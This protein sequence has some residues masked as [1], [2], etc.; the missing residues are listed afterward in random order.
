MAR[1]EIRSRQIHLDFHT[2]ELIR[3]IGSRFDPEEFAQTL[4][5]SRVNS[6]TLFSRCHHGMLY[7]DSKRFPERVHPHLANRNFLR[8]Q[9]E[10][11]RKRDIHI[12]LYTTVCWDKWVADRHP[13]WICINDKGELD[14]FK[15]KSYFEAGFYKNL[16]VNTGYRDYLKQQFGEVM[17]TIPAAGVWF[18]AA[19]VTECSCSACI[20]LMQEEGLDP[21][22]KEDRKKFSVISHYRFV[23]EMSDF[24]KK[25]N[26]DYN[27]FY[28]KGHVGTL[29]KGVQEAYTYYSFESLPGGE[30]G[31][32]DFPVSVKYNRNF[33]KEV[34]GLTGRFH[35]EWGDFHSFRNQAALEFECYSMIAQGAKCTIGDQLDPSG[36]LNPYMYEQI[37]AI[38][39]DI[40]RKEPWCE[41]AAAVTEIGVFT[42]EE[43]Y[44]A[45]VGVIPKA[46][47]GVARMLNELAHQ[48]DI[49]D[50]ESAFER[51]KLLILPDVIPVSAALAE[52]LENYVS[53][54]GKLL[55]SH[56]SGLNEEETAFAMDS[57]GLEYLGDAPFSP[58]FI[59]PQGPMGE[60]LPPSEHAMYSKGALVKARHG[61]EVLQEAIVPVFNRTWEH[62][63]SHLHS[64]SSGK[65]GYPAIV[66][67]ESAVYFIHPVF[68]QYQH[69]APA[70][71]KKLVRNALS[72]LL[73]KPL[74]RHSG[75]STVNASLMGQPQENRWVLHLL[76]YIPEKK[77]D[78]LEIIE[79]VIPLHNV[80]V[81]VTVPGPVTGLS[82]VPEQRE[83]PFRL[84]GDQLTFT[85]PEIRGHRMIS[86][87]FENEQ[88]I[89][90]RPF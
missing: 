36:K 28:N 83:L 8:D 9:A 47:E 79:D 90:R 18:D 65:A 15:G 55:V 1:N 58:D 51:Y 30:W 42:A 73:P 70:W 48:Y 17:A 53:K 45:G 60:G 20:R 24:A 13:E 16:C 43:F 66:S 46:T 64:P 41:G 77:C 19:F 89:Q 84:D 54:G 21:T 44:E 56:K 40:E 63:C 71:Y 26:P 76:H 85:V 57:L 80:Q 23:N 5:N 37:G 29:E 33:G 6:I 34:L 88:T 50:S 3:D 62:F 78:T 52:K 69:N 81:T 68:T 49:I 12:N 27:I 61:A 67:T 10:A 74:V 38:Y 31:Y 59:V 86:I 25:F 14:D 7:Y 82:A 87:Q 2:S 75:P 35:T 22:D 39:A 32:M 72:R 11:C 4:Q